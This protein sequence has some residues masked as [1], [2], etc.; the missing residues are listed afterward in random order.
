MGA[1]ATLLVAVPALVVEEDWHGRPMIDI[2][3]ALWIPFAVLVAASF[4]LGGLVAGR[5][6]RRG[7]GALVSGLCS[8]I[9]A[10]VVLVGA[11]LLRRF[12]IADTGLSI[13]VVRLWVIAGSGAIGLSAFGSLLTH[14][15]GRST[16][17]GS[18]ARPAPRAGPPGPRR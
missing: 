6:R 15:I 16:V 4:V 11:D 2:D 14:G 9:V 5:N 10:V 13:G 12:A 1:A 8:G 17:R 3:A 7:R 18:T